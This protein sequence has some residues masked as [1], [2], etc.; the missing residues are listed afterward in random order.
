MD[1]AKI[2]DPQTGEVIDIDDEGIEYVDS[3]IKFY[4]DQ[5]LDNIEI[6]RQINSNLATLSLAKQEKEMLI[7]YLKIQMAAM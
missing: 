7:E 1:M 6:L 3:L 2:V 5:E 4:L